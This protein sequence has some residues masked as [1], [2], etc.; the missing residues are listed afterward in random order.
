VEPDE[1]I[2]AVLVI[3]PAGHSS[4]A[5]SGTRNAMVIAVAAFSLALHPDRQAVGTGIGRPAPTPRRARGRE[6]FL[7]EA[8]AA[9]GLWNPAATCPKSPAAGSLI[10]SPKRRRDR[11]CPG[12]RTVP[13]PRLSVMARRALTWAWHEFRRT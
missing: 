1:L 13:G 7:A 10:W 11:R 6:D 9:D 4:S 8:L 12:Q 3:P 2:K 5:R